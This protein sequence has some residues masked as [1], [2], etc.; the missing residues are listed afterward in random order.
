[1][2]LAAHRDAPLEKRCGRLKD[3]DSSGEHE[4]ID[5]IEEQ[6]N[7]YYRLNNLIRESR[8]LAIWTVLT[9]AE[10]LSIRPI[11]QG[12][13]LTPQ[14]DHAH[15]DYVMNVVRY[16]LRWLSGNAEDRGHALAFEPQRYAD[17]QGLLEL[18][19]NYED[20]ACAFSYMHHGA[21]ELQLSGDVLKPV[22]GFLDRPEFE[23]Y[24][25]LSTNVETHEASLASELR[26]DFEKRVRVKGARF[27]CDVN[28]AYVR[29][30]M[31]LF[32]PSFLKRFQLPLAWR[33]TRY[34][35]G[36]FAETFLA[37]FA[38]CLINYS[39]RLLAIQNG[40]G[41]FGIADSVI[42]QSFQELLSRISRYSGIS[43]AKSGAILQDLTYGEGG[44]M[45]PDP[46]IQ[47]LIP[48]SQGRLALMPSIII[49]SSAERNLCVLLNRLGHE[50]DGYRAMA[51]Q[52]ES[53]LRNWILERIR[54]R[55]LR[56]WSGRVPGRKDLGNVDLAIVDDEREACL[57][58]E[59]KWFITPSDPR[60]WIEKSE[61]IAKGVSQALA[62]RSAFAQ[63]CSALMSCLGISERYRFSAMVTTPG[64]IGQ[65][66]SQHE[67]VPVLGT[68]HVASKLASSDLPTT[69]SWLERKDYLP[70]AG[71]HFRVVPRISKVGRWQLAWYGIRP[72]AEEL[73]CPV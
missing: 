1:M 7:R 48:L 23:A 22:H 14:Q 68:S 44:I 57:L 41:N 54:G 73:Y 60:E 45:Y 71:K 9:C 55:G 58:C 30:I 49:A 17:G 6:V 64:W 47:P 18:A 37:L 66:R 39:G 35:L 27:Y 43:T 16:P 19:Y 53:W 26:L 5:V 36:E 15:A 42:V 33:F 13:E 11:V 34:T 69:I 46:A 10:D 8:S 24:S 50:R 40:C 70:I 51:N 31:D 52:K 3:V 56:T 67:L 28:P 32:R 62:L 20:F 4:T 2:G 72:L 38:V 59:L 63:G 29:R 25:F 21:I 65:A 61:E 12:L